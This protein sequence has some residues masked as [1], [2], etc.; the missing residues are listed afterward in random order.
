[1]EDCDDSLDGSDESMTEYLGVADGSKCDVACI[2][3]GDADK[4]FKSLPSITS[5]AASADEVVRVSS[6]ELGSVVRFRLFPFFQSRTW[7][8]L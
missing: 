5:N 2:E 7:R 1:M 3:E 6:S 8:N 4:K